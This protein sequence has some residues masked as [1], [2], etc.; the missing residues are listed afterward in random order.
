MKK[1]ILIYTLLLAAIATTLASCNKDDDT[2]TTVVYG[3]STTSSLVSSF[4]LQE[5]DDVLENLDSVQF[6]IDQ[7]KRVIYNPDSLPYGTDV[8][9]LLCTISF[10][11]TVSEANIVVGGGT[12]QVNDTTISYTTSSTDSIDFTGRVTLNVIS[13]DA[14]NS[15]AYRI[16]VNVHQE[17]PD[18]ILFP[19]T[20]RRDLPAS[21]DNNYAVGMA[22]LGETFYSVVYN[23]NGRYMGTASTPAG[24]WETQT[25]TYG[26]TPVESSLT[27]TTDAL[28]ILDNAGNLYTSTDALSWI[29]TGMV[30]ESIIGSYGN[31][32]LGMTNDGV[33][34]YADEYPRRDGFSLIALPA[35][36]PVSGRSQLI[37][38]ESTWSL[39]ETALMVGGRDANGNLTSATWGYDGNSWG[40][41]SHSYDSEMPEIEGAALYGYITYDLNTYSQHATAKVTWVV[42]GGRLE[43]GTFN[44]VTYISRDMGITWLAADDVMTLPTYIPSFMNAQAFVCTEVQKLNAP[45]RR[46]SQAITEWD[47]PYVYIVGGT[48]TSGDLLNNVWKGVVA[49][50]LYKPVY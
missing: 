27:A 1:G 35:E 10:G 49:R 36:F 37:I 2:T 30:W 50:A 6:C 48:G 5:N 20:A 41:L 45:A 18:S 32:V 28:Y 33:A 11:T 17:N 21:A 9:H 4:V 19:I 3:T 14:T 13:A 39:G 43:D 22:R 34:R 26:F 25:V 31:R 12:V 47:V 40:E 29:P 15:V 7:E 42:M 46:I 8:T 16:Y 44:R 38:E 23:S 24:R